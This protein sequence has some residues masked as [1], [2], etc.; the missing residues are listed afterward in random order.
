MEQKMKVQ[1]VLLLKDKGENKLKAVTVLTKTAY[2][3][4]PHR[5]RGYSNLILSG[6]FG[7]KQPN[8]FLLVAPSNIL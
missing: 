1:V 2:L 6:F 7:K 5:T 8:I 4:E 3:M